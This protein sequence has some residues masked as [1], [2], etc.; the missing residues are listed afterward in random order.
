MKYSTLILAI[1]SSLILA[2]CNNGSNNNQTGNNAYIGGG[3][4]LATSLQWVNNTLYASCQP[5]ANYWNGNNYNTLLSS[6]TQG[7]NN[8]GIV[9]Q[10][11][12]G[13]I[14]G[15]SVDE[16]NAAY[17]SYAINVNTNGDVAVPTWVYNQSGTQIGN[18][19]TSDGGSVEDIPG[20][21]SNSGFYFG[22]SIIVNNGVLYFG[23]NAAAGDSIWM[24]NVSNSNQPWNNL[25]P[26]WAWEG[27]AS[28]AVD[29]NTGILYVLGNC[30]ELHYYANG[31]WSTYQDK[32]IQN[33]PIF[34]IGGASCSGP[35]SQGNYASSMTVANG[36]VYLL[37]SN[38]SGGSSY[39]YSIATA[40]T[41]AAMTPVINNSNT[42]TALTADASGNLWAAQVIDSNFDMQATELLTATN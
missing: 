36:N 13:A 7:T 17:Y 29:K 38:Q 11:Q 24:S 42:Y 30:G 18:D 27:T 3:S 32:T 31:T 5:Q 40:N 25:A 12:T 41:T 15:Y 19:G 6:A 4:C 35:L 9:T 23:G 22:N 33:S 14:A 26:N 28:A 8:W 37:L 39:L 20:G 34:G 10:D 2:A 1:S 21:F 16:T